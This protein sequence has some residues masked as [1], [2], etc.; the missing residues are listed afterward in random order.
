MIM[1]AVLFGLPQ[2]IDAVFGFQYRDGI[3][4]DRAA[5]TFPFRFALNE[6]LTLLLHLAQPNDVQ[7]FVVGLSVQVVAVVHK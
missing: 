2:P 3:F 1:A 6:L 5:V 7:Q 4:Q